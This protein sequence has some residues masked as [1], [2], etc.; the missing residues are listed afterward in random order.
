MWCFK[1]IPA[2]KKIMDYKGGYQ[3]FQSKNFCLTMPKT[4][5]RG[6]YCVVFQKNSR[7]EKDYGLE[8]GY[9]DLPVKGFLIESAENFR[10]GKL[11]CCVSEIFG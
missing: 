2:A 3:E 5:A 6:S 1:K 10:R 4:F 11:L 9:Q 7:S 8:R